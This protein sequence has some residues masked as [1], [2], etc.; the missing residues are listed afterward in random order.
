MYLVGFIIRIYYDAR[1][2]ERE[3]KSILL[4]PF[5]KVQG[6]IDPRVAGR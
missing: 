2:A 3:R 4:C 6:F 1:L 5:E